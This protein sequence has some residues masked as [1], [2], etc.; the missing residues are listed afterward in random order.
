MKNAF[1][2]QA[3]AEATPSAACGPI[4]TG[5]LA[6]RRKGTGVASFRCC[7]KSIARPPGSSHRKLRWVLMLVGL[8]LAW[9]MPGR[10]ESA[11][12]R[13]V[14]LSEC[15][16]IALLNNRA[17]QIQR[18]NPDIARAT[19]SASYGYYD[20]VFLA[21]ARYEDLSDSGGYDPADFSRDAIYTAKSD[22]V[23]MGITGLLPSGMTYAIGGDYANSRGQRNLMNFDSYN[24]NA[25][26]S[27]QQPLLRNF[28]TDQG[29]MTIKVNKKNLQITELGVAYLTMDVI[30]QVQQSY[31][32]LAFAREHVRVQERLLQVRDK[33]HQAVQ[34][35][36]Q[37]GTM[38]GPDEQLA[39]AQMAN[40]EAGL[41]AA[42]QAAALAENILRTL[43]GESFTN[44]PGRPLVNAD[45]LL[46][47]PRTFELVPAW[48]RALAGRPDL[49]QLREDVAKADIDL[50][51]R[52]N[53]LFPSFDVVAG[54]GRRG[55]STAQYLPPTNAMA[56]ASAAFDQIDNGDNPNSFIGLVFSL[57]LTRA[58]ERGAYRSSQH[59]R[60]QADLLVKQ[61][62]EW[63]QREIADALAV[64]R[65]ALDRATATRRA[66]DQFA[67][68]V[69]AE[70]RKLA[71]GKSTVFLVLQL[72]ADFANAQSAEARA[73]ADYNKAVSQFHFAEASLLENSALSIASIEIE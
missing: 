50:K 57:P 69:E 16:Q 5:L 18:V 34:R 22:V 64:V 14:T 4:S 45:P 19:L 56:S 24:I 27:V 15:I 10:A 42:T 37:G 1:L 41:A 44:E 26:I 73:K 51:Y 63:I 46:V 2:R 21:D 13:R 12:D 52:R 70:E 53:Q 3:E 39:A 66:C 9:T 67:K 60:T 49:Q 8:S 48:Q 61:K 54:Y 72:Q 30:N 17:L 32:E 36:V 59:L 47:L 28:W 25:A 29:R 33:L 43:M 7:C 11:R 40:A 38:T 35:Q 23:Q 31:Y 62:E 58:A 68:A 6:A 55:A 65:S 71:G 20:P